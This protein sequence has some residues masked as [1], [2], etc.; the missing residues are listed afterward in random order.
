[1]VSV[2]T[3]IVPA[4][5]SYVDTSGIVAADVMVVDRNGIGVKHLTAFNT[6][7][8]SQSIK[9]Y[10]WYGVRPQTRPPGTYLI[11]ISEVIGSTDRIYVFRVGPV[12]TAGWTYTLYFGAILAVYTAQAGDTATD[13]RDGLVAAVNAQTWGVS[14]T[15]TAQSTNELEVVVDDTTTTLTN[16]VGKEKWKNGYY[17]TITGVNYIVLEQE[18]TTSQPALPAVSA[19]YNFTALNI[20]PSDI[21]T[22]L[23]EPLYITSFSESVAGT[24]NINGVP[25][26]GNVPANECVVYQFG[27]K[28]YFELPLLAGE[29]I[30]VI[31]K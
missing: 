26:V 4:A 31:S 22:Y 21:Q 20:M 18:S 16:L 25:I 5:G 15:A 9:A 10:Q 8:S 2:K 1:M 30:N 11:E 29:I 14:V 27:Q 7:T 3:Y 28:I 23:T 19:S 24:A 13:V 6:G 17:V 12:P